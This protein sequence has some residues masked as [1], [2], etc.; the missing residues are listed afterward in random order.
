MRGYDAR[1]LFSQ[2]VISELNYKFRLP[3]CCVRVDEIVTQDEETTAVP[4]V[5]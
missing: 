1:R 4:G 3:G 2:V 5:G